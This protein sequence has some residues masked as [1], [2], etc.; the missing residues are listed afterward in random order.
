MCVLRGQSVAS[1]GSGII[2]KS[3]FHVYSIVCNGTN[4]LSSGFGLFRWCY[5]TKCYRLH[6]EDGKFYS[7]KN[8]Y[9]RNKQNRQRFKF[10]SFF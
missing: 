7:V 3:N 9:F 5:V 8:I 10:L 6:K 1:L 2:K 4:G